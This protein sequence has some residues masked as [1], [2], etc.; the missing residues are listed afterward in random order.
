MDR[1]RISIPSENLIFLSGIQ[2]IHQLALFVK[3]SIV[4]DKR[5]C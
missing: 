4:P 3:M 2:E 1:I 5:E